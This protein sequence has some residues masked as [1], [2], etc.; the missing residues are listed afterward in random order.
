MLDNEGKN[1]Y[2]CIHCPIETHDRHKPQIIP[3]AAFVVVW[4]MRRS[5]LTT[6]KKAKREREEQSKGRIGLNQQ[7]EK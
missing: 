4:I 6:Q 7:H 5:N 3:L 1:Q 2:L